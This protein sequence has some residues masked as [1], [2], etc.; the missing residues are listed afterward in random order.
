MVATS[1]P[2]ATQIGL[3][4]LKQGGT[5]IDA[6]I[7]ANIALGLME[8]T[9][10]GIGGDLFAIIWDAESKKLHGLNASGP[11]PK[12]LSIESSTKKMDILRFLKVSNNQGCFANIREQPESSYKFSQIIEL[13]NENVVKFKWCSGKKEE[14]EKVREA[15]LEHVTQVRYKTVKNSNRISSGEEIKLQLINLL[16][17]NTKKI[18]AN[19]K[20]SLKSESY[21]AKVIELTRKDTVKFQWCD[22]DNSKKKIHEVPLNHVQEVIDILHSTHTTRSGPRKKRNNIDKE[23]EKVGSI[24]T[25]TVTTDKLHLSVEK[26]K[27]YVYMIK[28]ID[29]SSEYYNDKLKQ[30]MIGDYIVFFEGKDCR[31]LD[32][33][34]FKSWLKETANKKKETIQQ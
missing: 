11:A 21:F 6:A 25:I 27:R 7:A 19:I 16:K 8:P 4:I 17:N 30:V 3:D 22:G 9:G 10:N 14:K 5:A 24:N 31:D 28:N 26:D 33:N 29:K 13:T 2:L 15:P 23:F 12:N 1:H 18:Y 20:H 32:M 34:S